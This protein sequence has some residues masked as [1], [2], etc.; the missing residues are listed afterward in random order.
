MSQGICHGLCQKV[1]PDG[2]DCRY[3]SDIMNDNI[4]GLSIYD[5]SDLFASLDGGIKGFIAQQSQRNGVDNFYPV[6]DN[7]VTIVWEAITPE[8]FKL[9][10]EDQTSTLQH[11]D[12]ESETKTYH[13]V[14][15]IAHT[16]F[17]KSSASLH[18]D[19]LRTRLIK[20]VGGFRNLGGPESLRRFQEVTKCFNMFLK[21]LRI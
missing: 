16:P 19:I 9:T 3:G 2:A 17:N 11:F 7:D 20:V 6:G 18:Y 14:T 1:M 8:T 13:N 15:D 5:E 21:V 12:V 10:D 4:I